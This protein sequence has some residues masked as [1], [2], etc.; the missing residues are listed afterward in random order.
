MTTRWALISAGF[1]LICA[2]LH[3]SAQN[4]RLEYTGVD[5]LEQCQALTAPVESLNAQKALRCLDYLKGHH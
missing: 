2:S 3:L 4:S 1:F 5:L